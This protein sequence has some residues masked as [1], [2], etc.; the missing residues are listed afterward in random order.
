M[1]HADVNGQR[2]AYE[3]TGSGQGVIVFS[4]GFFMDRTMFTPQVEALSD[5]WRC[6]TWDER[7]HGETEATTDAFTY[8][9]SARDLLALLD[10]LGVDHAVFAGMSQGGFLTLRAALTAPERVKAMVLIDT[11]QAPDAPETAA[12]YDQLILEGW[13]APGGPAPELRRQLADIIIGA[14]HPDGLRWIDAATSIPEATVRQIYK[15]LATRDDLTDR[16]SELTMPALV[17]HGSDDLAIGIERGRALAD[18]L[19]NGELVEIEGGGH[20]ANL[21]HPADVNA[22]IA[23]FLERVGSR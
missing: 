9:D 13:L 19:P 2:I 12:G 7:G 17:V 6:V 20:A 4:H 22:A 16:M 5:R 1:P 18:L 3:D 8:W 10:H 11:Q 23:A 15:T 21:T 14:G